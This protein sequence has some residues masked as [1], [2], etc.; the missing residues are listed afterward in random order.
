V[1]RLRAPQSALWTE[2]WTLDASPIWHCDL[3]GVPIILHQ[4]PEGHWSPQ[5]QP[6]SG[7]EVTIKVSRPAPVPGQTVT[8]EEANLTFTPGRRLNKGALFLK[9]RSSRGGQRKITLPDEA[10]LQLVKVM[11]KRQPLTEETEVIVPLRPGSQT[12]DVEWHEKAEPSLFTRAPRVDIGQE[13][14]NAGVT[15]EMPRNRWIL[16]CAGPRLGP[17]VL[18][19]T[20]LTVI[21][22]VAIGLGRLPWTPLKT[23]HW[24]LLGLGLTQVHPLVA[25]MIVGWLL[26][27]GLRREYP[28]RGGW[29]QFNMVQIALV[30]WTVAA[31]IGLYISVE[32]GLLGIPDMQISGNGSSDFRLHWT[33][34]RTGSTMPH[35]WVLSLPLFVYRILILSW[36]LWLAYALLKWL[37]WGWQCFS[38]GGWWRKRVSD[39]GKEDN[40]ESSVTG[41]LP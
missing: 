21:I 24:I 16:L 32:K 23:H 31:L 37:R 4:D 8:T 28:V 38:E 27:L 19:W 41:S 29:F 10:K 5:W 13:A 30:A 26:A 22:L 9:V 34:D 14:V 35:T 12:I 17:A 3:S 33:L 20:Y 1:I 11:G 25:I 2:S 15:F 40:G 6:W 36:A 39:R 18:F 7:E